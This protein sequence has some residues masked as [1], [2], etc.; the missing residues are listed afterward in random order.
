MI[1][2]DARREHDLGAIDDQ[3][4]RRSRSRA[5]RRGRAR[6]PRCHSVL[7][8]RGR[9]CRRPTCADRARAVAP[10]AR[11]VVRAVGVDLAVDGD[12]RERRRHARGMAEPD[13][14]HAGLGEPDAEVVDG[15]VRRRRAQHALAARDALAHDLDERARLAGAGRPPDQRDVARAQRRRRRRRAGARRARSSSGVPGHRRERLRRPRQRRDL[16]DH[17]PGRWSR[18]PPSRARSP[19]RRDRT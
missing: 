19:R 11:E 12:R 16:A 13:R 17:A 7:R 14:L 2:A 18:A 15:G 4:A 1:A 6:A 8:P 3:R 10:L 5:R 9:A